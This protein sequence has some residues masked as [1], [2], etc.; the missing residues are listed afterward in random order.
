MKIGETERLILR[1]WT[2][3]EAD[4]A[5]AM[6]IWADPEVMTQ[7]VGGALADEQAVR[8]ALGRAEEGQ[9]RDG[10]QL[11]AVQLR[12]S[13]QVVGACG[14]TV[15]GPGPVY[16]MSFQLARTHWGMGYATEAA[17]AA[18]AYG[19]GQLGAAKIVA[20]TLGEHPA[21]ARVLAKLGFSYLGTIVW[22]DNEKEDPYYELLPPEAG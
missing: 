17:R 12:S 7:V 15:F 14:F 9:Q 16:E 11:W 22:P 2:L 13:G 8:A 6:Q 10:V 18:I 4:V 19:F 5:A 1:T 3:Q 20:G 21:S